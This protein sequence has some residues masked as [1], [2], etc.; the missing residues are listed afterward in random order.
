MIVI[1]F[2]LVTKAQSGKLCPHGFRGDRTK[3]WFY[4]SLACVLSNLIEWAVIFFL[5]VQIY[6]SFNLKYLQS[7]FF[8]IV[9]S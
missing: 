1:I 2:I 6:S 7:P 3:F 5:V 4:V 8:L 9:L